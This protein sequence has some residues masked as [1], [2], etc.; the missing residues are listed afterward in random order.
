M[1]YS[2]WVR[3]HRYRTCLSLQ[4]V[5]LGCVAFS[6]AGPLGLNPL[7]VPQCP[8]LLLSGYCLLACLHPRVQAQWGKDFVGCVLL[9]RPHAVLGAECWLVEYKRWMDGWISSVCG[10]K[11]NAYLEFQILVKSAWY[12]WKLRLWNQFHVIKD[13]TSPPRWT[14]RLSPVPYIVMETW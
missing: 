7:Q 6:M 12:R 11:K 10:C 9:A 3:Q 2:Y 5:L 14:L 8:V 4:T 1:V 13:G